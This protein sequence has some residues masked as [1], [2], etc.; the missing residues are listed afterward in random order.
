VQVVGDVVVRVS[1]T[2]VNHLYATPDGRIC[3][4]VTAFNTTR[5]EI[6]VS[7]AEP[8]S[9]VSCRKLVQELWGPLAGG[10]DGIAGS[11]RGERRSLAD[12]QAAAERFAEMI[13]S[14]AK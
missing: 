6:T 2:F 7:L 11:P 5:G 8:V 14:A 1:S 12:L 13:R 9:G 4:G 10:H 3:R